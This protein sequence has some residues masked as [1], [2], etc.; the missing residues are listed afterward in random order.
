MELDFYPD[1]SFKLGD[2]YIYGIEVAKKIKNEI[3]GRACGSIHDYGL[4]AQT[5][6]YSGDGDY[7]ETGTLFGA[8]AL[9]AGLT[10]RKFNIKGKVYCVDPFDGY[11]G[12]GKKDM[13]GLIPSVNILIENAKKYRIQDNIIPIA[14]KSQP[15]P[16][17]LANSKFSMSFIDGNHWK[18][19]PK[20]D[21]EEY[22]DF[23]TSKYVMFDNY[24]FSHPSVV[25]AVEFAVLRGE[26][27]ICHVSSISF[28]I[29]R[30]PKITDPHSWAGET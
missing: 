22:G 18:D 17:E 2:A 20:K 3:K 10:K 6:F 16:L 9:V 1:S 19:F 5:V 15:L 24:D 26:W 23:R 7:V 29:Q 14:H 21:F 13:S 30:N 12:E 27:R 11:Y 28:I 8:S 25:K 4:L